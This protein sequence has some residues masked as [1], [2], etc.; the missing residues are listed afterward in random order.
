M[1]ESRS[2][3]PLN[4][5]FQEPKVTDQPV[6]LVLEL[7]FGWTIVVYKFHP[8][9]LLQEQ[10]LLGSFEHYLGMSKHHVLSKL[11]KGIHKPQSDSIVRLR[12]GKK[13]WVLQVPIDN[14]QALC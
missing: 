10:N 8:K 13:S 2:I 3:V 11:A 7:L 6:V 1:A 5:V 4:D 14:F 9:S 12:I